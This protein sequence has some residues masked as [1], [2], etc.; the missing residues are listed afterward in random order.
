M[1]PTLRQLEAFV[2]VVELGSVTAAAARM[3]LTQ[4]AVSLLLRELEKALG[5]AALFDRSKRSITLTEAGR[6]LLPRAQ[7]LVAETALLA[8][9]IREAISGAAATASLAA[10]AAM[11]SSIVPP[12]LRDFAQRYPQRKVVLFDVAPEA[13]LDHVLGGLVDLAIGTVEQ[14]PDLVTTPLGIDQF[15]VIAPKRS[16]IGRRRSMRWREAAELP[17]I[18]VRR[19]SAI[20]A[21]MDSALATHGLSFEPSREVSMLATALSLSAAGLGYA[22][23]PSSLV[24]Q[25]SQGQFVTIPL[26]EPTITRRI[27]LFARRGRP[28][29]VAAESLRDLLIEQLGDA[30]LTRLIGSENGPV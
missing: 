29:S 5:G 30:S 11:A 2:R 4:P 12:V 20:R 25:L 13:L 27:A 9:D 6:A 1:R 16:A 14:H 7:F 10:T 21:L 17:T 28:L 23:L 8:Q 22:I 18:T 3:A 15:C 24:P 26:E 19:G